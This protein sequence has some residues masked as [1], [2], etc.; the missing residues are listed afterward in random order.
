MSLVYRG[1]GEAYQ[2]QVLE[3][4]NGIAKQFSVRDMPASNWRM[5]LYVT[6]SKDTKL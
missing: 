3:K 1:K 2:T 4:Q 5:P 6:Y